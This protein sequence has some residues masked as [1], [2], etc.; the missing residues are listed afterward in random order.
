MSG[1]WRRRIDQELPPTAAC[2]RLVKIGRQGNQGDRVGQ[3]QHERRERDGDGRQPHPDQPLD[4]ARDQEH[5]QREQDMLGGHAAAMNRSQLSRRPSASGMTGS[6]SSTLRH[7]DRSEAERRDLFEMDRNPMV[8]ILCSE[9][10]APSISAS[11]QIWVAAGRASARLVAHTA[12]YN[13]HRLI[14]FSPHETA[15][16]HRTREATE[17]LATREGAH[18]HQPIESRVA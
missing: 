12:R 18:P 1:H 13:I 6:S 17:E 10:R 9:N 7:P 14:Y 11:R 2:H 8:Y 5:R 15:G 4:H 16:R 3:R